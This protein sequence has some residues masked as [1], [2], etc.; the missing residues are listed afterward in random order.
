MSLPLWKLRKR[1]QAD[2]RFF[3]NWR[4]QM[5]STELTTQF[6]EAKEQ[7]F[8]TFDKKKAWSVD[9]AGGKMTDQKTNFQWLNLLHLPKMAEYADSRERIQKTLYRCTLTHHRNQPSSNI[10]D[11]D[12][13]IAPAYHVHPFKVRLESVG[14]SLAPQ[15]RLRRVEFSLGADSVADQPALRRRVEAL[16]IPRICGKIPHSMSCSLSNKDKDAAQ[17]EVGQQSK[18]QRPLTI[19]VLIGVDHYYDFVTGRMKRNATGSIALET[20]LGWI[21]CGKP[22]SGPSKEARV[23]LTKVEEPTD[24]ALRKFWEIEAMGITPEDNVASEDTR[25]ME[26]FEKSLSFNGERYQVGL[27]W[28][29]GQPDLPVNVKQAMH[30]LTTVERRLAQSDKDS[31]D[32]SSTMRRYLVNGWAEPATESGPPRRTWYLPHHAVYKGEGEERKCRVVF[33]GSAR[34][35]QTSLNSQLEAG[36]PIQMD[37]LRALLRFRRFR[38]GLQADIENMYLQVQIR[39]EDRD[40]CRFLWRDETQEVCKYRLT[41]V[42]FSLTC[43]PF[44][45]V[46]TVRVHARRHQA[47]APR[48]ASE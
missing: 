12:D 18:P 45:A 8:L 38:V 23:L 9:V 40:V 15:R 48:A 36:P 25:M 37:L 6:K 34:Y 47:T 14:G 2:V 1:H 27:L 32:Y 21:I 31:C 33:D 42:C 3:S 35:G 41:R 43:S 46:S 29:E 16:A 13:E 11:G 28:R 24:A 19:D 22:H 39:E 26:R 44:L 7:S 10:R 4:D 30:R 5:S 17:T 20:L